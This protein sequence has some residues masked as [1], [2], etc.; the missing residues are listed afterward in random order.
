MNELDIQ[1]SNLR[2]INCKLQTSENGQEWLIKRPDGSHALAVGLNKKLLVK[3]EGSVGYYCGGMN[4]RS[5]IIINGSAGPG[6][7]ENIMSGKVIV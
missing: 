6:L 1:S 4:Q 7:A 5:E 3:I 2:E